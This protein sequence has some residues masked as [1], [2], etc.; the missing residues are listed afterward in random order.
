MIAWIKRKLGKCQVQGCWNKWNTMIFWQSTGYV[1]FCA[2]CAEN[3]KNLSLE[4]VISEVA[5]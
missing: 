3:V 2:H 5:R 1:R 4:P